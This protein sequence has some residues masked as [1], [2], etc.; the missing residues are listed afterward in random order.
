MH[1]HMQSCHSKAI[2]GPLK[3]A[4]LPLHLY[5]HETSWKTF[6]ALF[7]SAAM[8]RKIG[9]WYAKYKF[10]GLVNKR[11]AN[12]NHILTQYFSESFLLL[13]KR[14]PDLPAGTKS[15]ASGKKLQ[16]VLESQGKPST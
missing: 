5:P 4:I 14:P 8:E 11:V 2:V 9:I 6:F 13:M 16:N 7:F 10:F 15:L 12:S 1:L 3:D